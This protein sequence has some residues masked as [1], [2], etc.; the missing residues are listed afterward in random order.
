MSDPGQW[1]LGR[2]VPDPMAGLAI[3]VVAVLHKDGSCRPLDRPEIQF[4]DRG[5]V[6]FSRAVLGHVDMGQWLLFRCGAHARRLG[7]GVRIVAARKL[8]RYIDLRHLGSVE[9]IRRVVVEDGVERLEPGIWAVRIDDG[10]VVVVTLE[11]GS[12]DKLRGTG[13]GLERLSAQSFN[14]SAVIALNGVA[15]RLFYDAELGASPLGVLNWASDADYVR[16]MLRGLDHDAETFGRLEA[17]FEAHL[18]QTGGMVTRLG[19]LDL[20]RANAL[21]R[22]RGLLARLHQERDLLAACASLIAADRELHEPIPSAVPEPAN[23][24]SPASEPPDTLAPTSAPR[25]QEADLGD[26][27]PVEI[28][29]EPADDAETPII[30]SALQ[31][32]DGDP[33]SAHPVDPAADPTRDA[34]LADGADQDAA[35]EPAFLSDN[36]PPGDRTIELPAEPSPSSQEPLPV[37]ADRQEE[38]GVGAHAQTSANWR[39]VLAIFAAS[40]AL[41]AAFD[42][43]ASPA[44]DLAG[45]E[46]AALR[47]FQAAMEGRE[48]DLGAPSTAVAIHLFELSER[49]MRLDGEEGI[50]RNILLQLAGLLSDAVEDLVGRLGDR[51]ARVGSP[52]RREAI[53]L[54]DASEA[55]VGLFDD[56]GD[57]DCAYQATELAGRAVTAALSDE[58]ARVS[59]ILLET[60]RRAA[61]FGDIPRAV[62]LCDTAIA[63]LARAPHDTAA[64]EKQVKALRQDL[65]EDRFLEPQLFES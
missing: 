33:D 6:A 55:L 60:A 29:P 26:A 43:A 28:A 31:A 32:R 39:A 47:A 17:A 50:R 14:P 62:A 56:L 4:P 16:A 54:A 30:A 57:P 25:A 61:D 11:K 35:L 3:A 9:T 42:D 36:A 23:D 41:D 52:E 40:H 21:L 27:A 45:E 22:T 63:T 15:P 18:A 65:V 38:S 51:P 19:R 12:D 13:A 1:F 64:L 10:A 46:R 24:P 49:A 34:S 20:E 7:P 44:M 53:E 5:T 59:R 8:T 48:A 58:P 37:P 2:C